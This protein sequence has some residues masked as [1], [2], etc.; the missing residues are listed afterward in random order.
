MWK[1]V[2]GALGPCG[3][4]GINGCGVPVVLVGGDDV[5]G[6]PL[7]DNVALCAEVLW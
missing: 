4:G 2:T 7:Q 6:L 5:V 3:C 1:G